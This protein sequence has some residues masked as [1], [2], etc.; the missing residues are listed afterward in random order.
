MSGQQDFFRDF[1]IIPHGVPAPSPKV[2][3]YL[4]WGHVI[5]QYL[6]AG[7]MSSLAIGMGLVCILGLSFPLNVLASGA[8]FAGFGYLV[9]HATRN[10]YSWVELDGETLRAQHLYTRRCIERSIEDIEDLL[11][12]VSAIRTMETLITESLLG[13]VRGI[14]IRFRDKRTPIYI[15]RADP[16]M[17]N[18]K[19][20]IEAIIFRMSEKAPLDAELINFQGKPLIR[21]IYRK[22]VA[23][24]RPPTGTL[25]QNYDCPGTDAATSPPGNMDLAVQ[26]RLQTGNQFRQANLFQQVLPL[27]LIGLAGLA[28]CGW[29]GWVSAENLRSG[30]WP[31]ANGR[32]DAVQVFKHDGNRGIQY[33][34]AIHYRFTVNGQV[35]RGD[36][37][38]TR[39][40]YLAGEAGAAEVA[41]RY[42]P[43]GEC[44]VAYNPSNPNRCFIDTSLTYH[45]WGK[46]VIAALAGSGGLASFLFGAVRIARRR[47][48]PITSFPYPSP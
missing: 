35:Y 30:T 26:V 28:A 14:D 24:D 9:Y 46:I 48:M 10:D 38:N 45:T 40:N 6:F 12:R 32:V 41:K 5:A 18:A 25:V 21:R 43:S 22:E 8:V 16:A 4:P 44:S 37:F 23:P 34:V 29:L 33:S 17:K 11:T 39:G 13:R 2:R 47:K 36:R 1:G 42:R 19:E 3:C 20:L 27:V 7:L 15:S 31:R